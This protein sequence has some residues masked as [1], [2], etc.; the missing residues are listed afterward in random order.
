MPLAGGAAAGEP[1]RRQ[2]TRKRG[3][4]LSPRLGTAELAYCMAVAIKYMKD[5]DAAADVAQDAMLLA[6]RHRDSFRGRS[7][8]STWLYRIASTTALMHLRKQRRNAA[9]F[10]DAP[11][12][13]A[14]SEPE[15]P[16]PEHLDP[17]RR[18]A[19]RQELKVA[20][21]RLDELGEHYSQVFW[22]RYLLGYTES[23]IGAILGIRV[24]TV[25]SR[26]HRARV[27]VRKALC[28]AE[29]R[30]SIRGAASTRMRPARTRS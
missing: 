25:K 27:E 17:E 15:S 21:R 24:S 8:Y 13:E 3:A 20:E 18:A 22:M 11:A 5:E 9:H 10:A 19:D 23:E 29:P 4:A 2:P 26:A 16:Q 14:E 30:A 12:L 1:R 7:Q 6:H 28:A